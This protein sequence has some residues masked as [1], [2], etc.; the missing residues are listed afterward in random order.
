MRR[1]NTK[2]PEKETIS[3]SKKEYDNILAE[4]TLLREIK[5]ISNELNILQSLA[6]DQ[7]EVCDRLWGKEHERKAGFTYETPSEIKAE[8][9]EMIKDAETVRK[10]LDMLLDLKQKQANINQ[11]KSSRKQSDETAKQGVAIMVFT[12]VTTAFVSLSIFA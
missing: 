8:I 5:D 12:L 1:P 10:S 2:K 6:E 11:A 3:A 9:E 7:K 4:T